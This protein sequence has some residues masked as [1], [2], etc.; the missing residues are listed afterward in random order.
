MDF[1]KIKTFFD[2]IDPEKWMPNLQN[3]VG[4]MEMFVNILVLIA[5]LILVFLGFVYF[6]L[7]PKE[8]NHAFGYQFF[9]GKSSVDAW[10]FMQKVAGGVFCVLGLTLTITML[11]LNKNLV[12]MEA[13]RMVYRAGQYLIW[14]LIAVVAACVLIDLT[15][16]FVYNFRGKRRQYR[17]IKKILKKE[18]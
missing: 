15:V 14:E 10:H 4:D 6:F 1:D 2:E 11:I 5:P 16:L 18:V 9:W 7:P 13:E 8:A 12:G 3:L 17:L